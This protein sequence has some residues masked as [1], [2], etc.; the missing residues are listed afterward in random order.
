M[1]PKR[2]KALERKLAKAHVQEA[3]R[4]LVTPPGWVQLSPRERI[5]YVK[6]AVGEFLRAVAAPPV[7]RKGLRP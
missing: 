2:A 7:A 3:L 6:H 5:R 1:D 4:L